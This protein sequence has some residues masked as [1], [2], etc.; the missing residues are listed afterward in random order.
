[1]SFIFE[2]YMNQYQNKQ[3]IKNPDRLASL[4]VLGFLF[5]NVLVD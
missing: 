1:V 4:G 2:I 3:S 5:S